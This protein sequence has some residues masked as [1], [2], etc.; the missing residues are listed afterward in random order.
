[1][2]PSSS[3]SANPID[4]VRARSSSF[5]ISPQTRSAGRSS[6]GMVRQ[7]AFVVRV[8]REFEARRELDG[9][10]HAQAVVAER[11][12]G[13]RRAAARRSR[14]PRPSNG[15]TYSPVSGSQEMALMVKSR[16]R[17][18]S[19]SEQRRVAGDGEAAV[20]AAGLRLAPRQRHVESGD[21]VDG[22]ALADGVDAAERA[23]ASLA[24]ASASTPKTSTSMSFDGTTHQPIADPAADDQRASARVAHVLRDLP[25][26][27][28]FPARVHVHSGYINTLRVP[29][30]STPRNP[31][32]NRKFRASP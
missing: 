13:R 18:A 20:P 25:G 8:D 21:L 32:I 17:A 9:A 15:S 23:A 7:S 14:S 3:A 4:G 12:A 31:A 26:D 2:T 30:G 10:Q 27:F 6:S 16:R 5:S 19:S 11:P 29:S 28:E 1:M 22:E 24:A